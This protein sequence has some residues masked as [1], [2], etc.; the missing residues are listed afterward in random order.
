MWQVARACEL[1]LFIGEYIF[2]FFFISLLDCDWMV[3]FCVKKLLSAQQK[4]LS[5]LVG[6]VTT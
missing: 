6:K 2:T 5:D 1:V 3:K 4:S